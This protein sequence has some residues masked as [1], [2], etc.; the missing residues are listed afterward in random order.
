MDVVLPQR[1]FLVM[2]IFIYSLMSKPCLLMLRMIM[3]SFVSSLASMI[4]MD[5][6]QVM[7]FCAS[8]TSQLCTPTSLQMNLYQQPNTIWSRQCRQSQCPL[9]LHGTGTYPTA[10]PS[11][12]RCPL[13]FAEIKVNI[14]LPEK[15]M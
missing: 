5:L 7:L 8:W 4:T 1:R 9:Y 10:W 6:F 15:K 2:L 12:V 14:T 13:K 3:I 11:L